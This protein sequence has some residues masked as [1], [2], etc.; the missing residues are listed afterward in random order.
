MNADPLAVQIGVD[1]EAVVGDSV[2]RRALPRS[3][4]RT[5][6]AWCFADHFGPDPVPPRSGLQVGPHPH[7]GLQTVTWLLDGEV[8]HT[9]SL[10]SDQLIRP[11]QLNVMTAGHGVAHAEQTPAGFAG[12]VH[13]VQLW[14][15]QPEAT[16]HGAAAFEHHAALPVSDLGIG[17]AAVLVGTLGDATSPARSDTAQV[18]AQLDLSAG[19]A[20]V[21]L[22]RDFEHGLMVLEGAVTVDGHLIEPGVI[23]FL[24]TGRD[25]V[26]IDV[27]VSARAILIGGTPFPETIHMWWNFV[28]RSHGEIDVARADWEAQSDRYGFVAAALDRIPAPQTSWPKP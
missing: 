5:I 22:R 25:E 28:A 9:D 23:A 18:G 26:V 21:G 13:G 4:R 2:V 11:G 15:A 10:G 3:E 12:A 7:I 1:H 19:A 6:G 14:V 24:G 17:T 20:T 27:P 16:R 8:L